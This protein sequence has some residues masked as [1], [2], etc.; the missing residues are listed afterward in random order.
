MAVGDRCERTEKFAV[1]ATRFCCRLWAG[2][3]VPWSLLDQ[4]LASSASVGSNV[5]EGQGAT[6]HGEFIAKYR[7]SLREA[8]ESNLRLRVLRKAEVLPAADQEEL[9]WL[10]EESRRLKL[11][12]GKCIVTATRTSRQRGQGA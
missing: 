12:P 7:I 8:R 10:I 1:R 2:R 3:T 5:E 6:S 4:I 11:I 9:D